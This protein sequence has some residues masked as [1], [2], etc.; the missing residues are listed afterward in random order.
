MNSL[1]AIPLHHYYQKNGLAMSRGEKVMKFENPDTTSKDLLMT[2]ASSWE[3]LST[4]SELVEALMA[5]QMLNQ[6]IHPS[7]YGMD[8]IVWIV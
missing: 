1:Q 2:E 5:W 3:P 6:I 4:V 8:V 7:H